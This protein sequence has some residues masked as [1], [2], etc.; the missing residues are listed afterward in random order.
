MIEKEWETINHLPAVVVINQAGYRC[1]YVGIM[2]DHILYRKHYS[3]PVNELHPYFDKILR[4]PF[5]MEKLGM[6]RLF[7]SLYKD[8]LPA[9]V[10][11]AHGGI[12]Y[13]GNNLTSLPRSERIWWFGF[14]CAHYEDLPDPKYNNL[15][16][17]F[18]VEGI[19]R[20]LDYCIE[21]C[22]NLAEQLVDIQGTYNYRK[23]LL[24]LKFS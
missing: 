23:Y 7:I 17:F 4:E 19:V 21:E 10:L 2:E 14:D 5:E 24:S 22:E 20:T 11:K 18:N 9:S 1:G 12:T 15:E 13:S 8:P 3:E 16:Y 6:N